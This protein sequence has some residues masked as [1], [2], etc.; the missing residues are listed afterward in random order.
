MNDL[1]I[2]YLPANIW[3]GVQAMG[4]ASEDVA[5][6]SDNFT[7][8]FTDQDLATI[9]ALGEMPEIV[10]ALGQQA[11]PVGRYDDRGWDRYINVVLPL[12]KTQYIR[13]RLLQAIG[14]EHVGA[15]PP[16]QIVNLGPNGIGAVMG[17][18]TLDALRKDNNVL[19]VLTAIVQK[20]LIHGPVD[21]LMASPCSGIVSRFVTVNAFANSNRAPSPV[22]R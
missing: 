14:G 16:V 6:A 13:D 10:Q 20:A 22:Y 21:A 9:A 17:Q 11:S 4:I 5:S 18:G 1:R 2:I 19:V 3:Q 15:E 8:R 7:S 12:S